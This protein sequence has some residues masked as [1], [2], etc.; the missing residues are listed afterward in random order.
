MKLSTITKPKLGTTY[1]CHEQGVIRPVVVDRVMLDRDGILR[2][3]SLLGARPTGGFISN[4]D[5]AVHSRAQAWLQEHG[6]SRSW[7][8]VK[9]ASRARFNTR[10]IMQAINAN[11]WHIQAVVYGNVS[12]HTKSM[13]RDHPRPHPH[14]IIETVVVGLELR[15]PTQGCSRW[16][17]E[18]IVESRFHYTLGS[19]ELSH[20][21]EDAQEKLQNDIFLRQGLALEHAPEVPVLSMAVRDAV[22]GEWVR[23]RTG[24]SVESDSKEEA[25]TAEAKLKQSQEAFSEIHQKALESKENF[26]LV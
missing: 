5:V 3:T 18:P 11:E 25:S 15:R 12:P 21:V 9:K 17:V 8:A 19:Q 4:D 7:N 10:G 16:S 2:A 6:Q 26:E 1:L 23:K 14:F 13:Y 24:R 22:I 20:T